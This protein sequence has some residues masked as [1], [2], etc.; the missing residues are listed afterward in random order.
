MLCLITGIGLLEVRVTL[1]LLVRLVHS[2][3]LSLLHEQLLDAK[4]AKL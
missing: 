2:V 1:E 3:R 4:R